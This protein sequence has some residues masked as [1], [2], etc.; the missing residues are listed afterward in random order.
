MILASFV[1]VPILSGVII[2]LL[3]KVMLKFNVIIVEMIMFTTVCFS[4]FNLG[5]GEKIRVLL[6]AEDIILGISLTAD[7]TTFILI[8]LS[9]ILFGLCFV[10]SIN[11]TF[12][13]R[14]FAMLFLIL[15]GLLCGVFLSDDLFNIYV[16]LEVATVVVAILIMF[17]REARSIYDGM[18]YLLSQVVCM[19]FYL[20]G[21]GYMYKVFGVLSIEQI[22]LVISEVPKQELI[23]P[24]AFM[25][26]GICLKSAFFP[27]FSWL[28]RAH[29]TPSAPSIVS[30]ILSG[31]YVKNGI[32]LFFVMFNLFSPVLDIADY[33]AV[34]ASITA[35]CGFVMA[36]V[37]TDFKLVL[38]FHTISQ[39]GLIALGF[40]MDSEMAK[41]GA[42]YHLI[43]HAFFKSL[44]FLSAGIIIKSYQT[45]DIRKMHGV[46]KTLP[47]AGFGVII[48]VLG[49][50][51]APLFNGSVSK[52]FMQSG[53]QGLPAEYIMHIINAGTILSFIKI[54][55]ILPGEK[56]EAISAQKI[57]IPK[58]ITL[59]LLSAACLFG[60]VF[61]Q[62]IA[63][64]I[65]DKPFE[66]GIASYAQK[67]AVYFV[68]MLAGYLIY[69]FIIA[70]KPYIYKFQKYSLNFQQIVMAMLAFFITT[71]VFVGF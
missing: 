34:I 64:F 27:L 46:L 30:A 54:L 1:I 70:K 5:Q 50:T 23:M 60:G 20:F 7:K 19:V 2:Y 37:Q 17:K 55:H 21:V 3:P 52:Y 53:A 41:T 10:Y 16:L 56:Q 71:I 13:S 65:A 24:F 6:G 32:Y 63:S 31:L 40:C 29:G 45:R 44:L 43:N 26:T 35:I 8:A 18:I 42:F 12:F 49:I 25:M 57:N 38:A 15:Q 48:G 4:L 69:K 22:S 33:F 51:G 59:L 14:E 62:E 36:I 67:T 9:I 11:D 61:G 47:F 39:I 66:I 58:K 28:P 68:M